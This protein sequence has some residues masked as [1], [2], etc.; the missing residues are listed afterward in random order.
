MW[1]WQVRCAGISGQREPTHPKDS[2][3]AFWDPEKKEVIG[4][5]SGALSSL[6]GSFVPEAQQRVRQDR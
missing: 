5:H 6:P 1:R 4:D 3:Q 2:L